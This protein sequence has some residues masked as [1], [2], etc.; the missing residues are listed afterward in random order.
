MFD[1][2]DSLVTIIESGYLPE[3]NLETIVIRLH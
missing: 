1:L 3:D 2:K